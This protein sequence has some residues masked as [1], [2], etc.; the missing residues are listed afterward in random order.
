MLRA[1]THADHHSLVQKGSQW[2][3]TRFQSP[4]KMARPVA[5]R[6]APSMLSSDFANLAGEAARMVAAGADWLHMDVMVRGAAVV[7]SF[8]VTVEV[9]WRFVDVYGRT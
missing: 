4:S 8:G 6:I 2:A 9:L 5:A 1:A 7:W 3:T